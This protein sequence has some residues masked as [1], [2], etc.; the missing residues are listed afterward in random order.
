MKT[1]CHIITHALNQL[2][3]FSSMYFAKGRHIISSPQTY[4]IKIGG[5]KSNPANNLSV[6]K[7]QRR[8]FLPFNYKQPTGPY[9]YP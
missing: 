2:V 9:I 6:P 8:Y 7:Q 1:G 3:Y 4:L 5:K